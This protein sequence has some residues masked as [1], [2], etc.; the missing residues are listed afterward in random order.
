MAEHKH[1]DSILAWANGETLQYESNFGIWLDYHTTAFSEY[2]EFRI[3]PKDVDREHAENVKKV[4][5]AEL[6]AAIDKLEREL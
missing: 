2:L 4:K 5:I 3:K 1:R 6:K